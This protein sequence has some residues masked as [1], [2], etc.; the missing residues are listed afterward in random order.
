MTKRVL[1]VLLL[2]AG[3][4]SCS[5][6]QTISSNDIE[7][8]EPQIQIA[9]IDMVPTEPQK[10]SVET[11]EKTTET[12]TTN[13][14]DELTY[15]IVDTGQMFCYN[16]NEVLLIFPNP[17]EDYYGQDAQ[18]EGYQPSYTLSNDGK[19]V[20]DNV[21]GLTWQS[22]PN[23]TNTIPVY[24]DKKNVEQAIDVP[25]ELN[26]IAY[27]GYTD[28]RLPTIKELYSLIL[29]S[30]KDPS[31]YS[32]TDT[33]VLTPFIDT[34]YFKFSYGDIDKDGRLLESQYYSTATFIN[35]PG[36][37]GFQKQFGVNFA[38]GRI[39]G[40]DVESPEGA[41]L[42][43]VQCVRGNT[44]YGINNFVDNNDGTVTDQA[45]GLMW[46]KADSGKALTWED[47]LAWVQGKNSEKYLGYD[48]WRLPTI[49]ELNSIVDYSNAPE[50]NN[51][52]AINTDYFET[53]SIINEQG[54]G[55]YPYFWSSTTHVSYR[56]SGMDNVGKAAA[57]QAFGRALGY[58]ANRWIDVH[59]AGAQRSDPK[60]TD[61]SM[62]TPV[63]VNGIIG[64]SFGP[65]KDAVRAL[66]FVRLVRDK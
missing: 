15:K 13:S 45:T 17:G 14:K 60:N 30:G 31:G 59:G 44:S 11:D 38:D 21:T 4:I 40:Y 63:T 22:S 24:E 1:S 28:W 18:H 52:P 36:D 7:P 10:Q 51:K 16:D 46:S 48:N 12:S 49:K 41:F 65:Q 20:Y 8:T 6:C 2:V 25:S 37:R 64:Y 33:S 27:G 50:Y 23:I 58:F 34:N 39:K 19:T 57:Y 43:Y 62:Y 35:N 56:N 42:F 66:N 32:G 55:D 53:T 54:E 47:A 26:S 3:F 29:F 9:E 61:M 5:S